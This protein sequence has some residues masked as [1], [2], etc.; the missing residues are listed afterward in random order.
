MT[1]D[2]LLPP[3]V[4]CL[5]PPLV[6][7]PELPV[8][9]VSELSP[10]LQR[11]REEAVDLLAIT[12]LS[13]C[14]VGAAELLAAVDPG[15]V[16]LLAGE[17][18][19]PE[20][21]E[22]FLPHFATFS[23][24]RSKLS[25]RLLLAFVGQAHRLR[26]EKR[27]ALRAESALRSL[28]RWCGD[29]ECM[30]RDLYHDLRT[31]VAIAL[32]YSSNLLDGIE[33]PLEEK[34]LAVLQRTKAALETL[35][36][37]V[38]VGPKVPTLGSE[39]QVVID[40]SPARDPV[41]R[42]VRLEEVAREVLSLVS[43]EAEERK[44]EL[45]LVASSE[46]PAVWG[47]RVRLVQLLL[48]LVTNAMRHARTRVVVGIEETRGEAGPRSLRLVVRD[49]GAGFGTDAPEKFLA[50]GASGDGRTGLGL[51]IV[52]E[53]AKEHGARVEL[54]RAPSGGAEVRLDLPVDP[55]ARARP[56]VELVSLPD[57]LELGQLVTA[58]AERGRLEFP[59]EAEFAALFAELSE[60]GGRLVVPRPLAEALSSMLTQIVKT[61]SGGP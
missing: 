58:L 8:E 15:L 17:G 5:G 48:N 37:L 61:D 33:G 45:E 60:T 40:T 54:G 24:A 29:T 50:R 23:V 32:G 31:P 6:G 44:L 28:R 27:R 19:N 16:V 25:P 9:A 4:L 3:R 12:D 59:R 35:K 52:K 38:E 10:V 20:L 39:A 49:D 26:A 55:R 56:S 2:I 11:L 51:S 22:A 36:E 14:P 1:P 7:P 57:E 47:E 34:Q 46:P 13:R 43:L 18:P 21:E 42:R 53:I 30:L 41:R